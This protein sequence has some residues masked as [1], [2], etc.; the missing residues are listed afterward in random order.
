MPRT[1]G[2]PRATP[3]GRW[4][5][6]R[7]R[8]AP[9]SRPPISTGNRPDQ[10]S[11]WAYDGAS[12]VAS[13]ATALSSSGGPAWIS[14]PIRR[15]RRPKKRR[16]SSPASAVPRPI[17]PWRSPGRAARAALV[18][19]VSDDAVGR[20]AVNELDRYGVDRRHV[21]PVGGEAR[22]S[23]AVVETPD[24]G[25]PVGDLPQR[26]GRLRDDPR[27]C[28]SGRLRRL[29]RA[30]RN[31]HGAGRRAVTIC[32]L[33]RVRTRPRG[34]TAADL[35]RGLPALSA[36]PP[37]RWRPRSI[38]AP[39]RSATSIVG[40]DARVRLHGGRPRQ[41]AW[42]WP[43]RW[44]APVRR[45][46]IYKMGEAGAITLTPD[47]ELR[48]GIYPVEALK[49]TG[50]GDGFLGGLHRRPGPGT[51]SSRRRAARF[52]LRVDRRLACGLRACDA[53]AG[54]AGGV[55]GRASRPNRALRGPP[56]HIAPFDN[57]NR[58][59]VDVDDALRSAQLLQHR[60]AEAGR[61][62]RLP[63]AGIR[64]LH[65]SGDGQRW[66]SR[67]RGSFSPPSASAASTSGTASLRASMSRPARRRTIVCVSDAAEIFV[68]GARFDGALDAV[69]RACGRHR[70]RAIWLATT[71]RRTARSSISSARSST[72]RSAAC[73]CRELFT[74][75]QGGWSGFPSH[76]HDTD[77][78]P[79]RDA[80]RRDLQLPLPSATRLRACKCSSVRKARRATPIM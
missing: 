17:S 51:R 63:H 21:T 64:D 14:I 45:S 53:D 26:R 58:P 34:G 24:G 12:G 29:Q 30:D 19:R 80:A 57:Q 61:G 55:P 20:F 42:N 65:R 66:T 23:L 62:V 5:R 36:G 43:G 49:P 13:R 72:A 27:G 16:A 78:L 7:S 9:E 44:S 50:A 71:P 75:G 18:T 74:V 33:S 8:A 69:R 11:A 15:E 22:N 77:R 56:M 35:R 31:R 4:A 47:A 1:A 48:T 3:G 41:G 76:K 40:N 73:W 28:R 10:G 46:S 25:P 6:R 38:R 68:A 39:R 59:I 52:R 32:R 70:Q 60:Q 79:D 54:R 67:S 37:R 2:P